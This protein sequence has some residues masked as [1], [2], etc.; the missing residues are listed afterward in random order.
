MIAVLILSFFIFILFYLYGVVVCW[1]VGRILS[2]DMFHEMSLPLTVLLGQ[3]A[4]AVIAMTAHLFIPL[5]GL[6]VTGLTLGALAIAFQAR[7]LFSF[8]RPLYT[9]FIWVILILAFLAVLENA[10]HIP[11][12]PD[13]GL[14]HVQTVRWFEIY[15]I[16]PGLGNFESRYAFNSSWLVLNASLSFAFL[17]LRSF[18]LVNGVIFITVFLYFL[19]GLSSLANKKILVSNVI[20]TLFLPLSFYLLSSEISSL[21]NDM[22]IT[23]LTWV[24]LLLWVEKLEV[25]SNSGVKDVLIVLLSSFALTVKLSSLPL[26]FFALFIVVEYSRKKEWRPVLFLGVF[27][28]LIILPWMIRSVFLSGYLIFP[29]TQLDIFSVDWK[30]PKGI[31][32]YTVQ[33]IVGIARLGNSWNPSN[34]LTFEQ[35]VPK[36]FDRF[37]D[38]RQAMILGALFS[39]LFVLIGWVRY[40]SVVSYKFL[41]AFVVM[42]MGVAFWFF[43]APSI[44]F[45][46]GFLVAVCILAVS[47]FL[48]ELLLALSKMS[49]IVLSLMVLTLAVFQFYSFW[50]SL[51]TPTLSQ[52]WL[53]PADYLPSDITPCDLAGITIACRP[54]GTL[55]THCFY[56]VFPCSTLHHIDV[57]LRGATYQDGFKPASAPEP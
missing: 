32:D 12:N 36:W 23:F 54:E 9:P 24:I 49:S 13:T 3:M 28:A 21:G 34:P 16:V 10:T 52:R 11:L 1:L 56:D 51:D 30:M 35:W 46:Y 39:P 29:Q 55:I 26:L 50:Y 37:T 14:Y 40:R 44:R 15:R 2:V 25:P 47:P 45:G 33:G 5:N 38:N 4:I 17:G 8:S 18:H 42:F 19:D 48:T 43:A 7:Y 27:S 31:V 20:K 41:F 22:P 53:L 57:K 6:F